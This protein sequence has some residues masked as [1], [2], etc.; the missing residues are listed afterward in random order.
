MKSKFL[1]IIASAFCIM[2]F[3]AIFGM[4]HMDSFMILGGNYYYGKNELNKAQKFY[5]SAFD[6]GV[7]DKTARENYVNS[8]INSPLTIT[9]QEKLVKFRSIIFGLFFSYFNFFNQGFKFFFF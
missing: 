4:S 8:I 3:A 6:M 9:A 5:E 7:T 2:L 1:W